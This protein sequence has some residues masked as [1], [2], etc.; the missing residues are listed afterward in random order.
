MRGAT[1]GAG[2]SRGRP[3]RRRTPTALRRA[4]RRA[5]PATA[6]SATPAMLAQVLLDLVGEDLQAAA[7]DHRADAPVDPHEAVVVDAGE[8]AGAQ[9]TV[10][11]DA[12]HR[13]RRRRQRGRGR[14]SSSPTSSTAASVVVAH[15]DV[16]AGVRTADRA[17]LRRAELL[18]VGRAPADH[19]AAELG[20]AVA[21]EDR[22]AEAVV[23]APRVRGR[24]RR[25]HAAHVAQRLERRDRRHRWAASPSR[26][27]AAPT[28]G[29]RIRGRAART[30]A[31]SNCSISTTGA[32]SV[33]ANSTW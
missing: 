5:T 25:R 8:V 14:I 20:L 11:G 2:G 28:S 16:D 15:A 30:R 29:C 27:A 19:L 26:R 6:A 13:E 32:P 4:G 17:E 9:P 18:P 7:V 1:A 10:G 24:E 3:R 23:E 31:G 12:I 22:D 33:N 21:V